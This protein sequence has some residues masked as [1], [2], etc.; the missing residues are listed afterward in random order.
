MQR[1]LPLLLLVLLVLA[2]NLPQCHTQPSKTRM[3]KISRQLS[4]ELV[5]SLKERDA[6]VAADM[7]RVER[8][9]AAGTPRAV[10]VAPGQPRRAS[11]KD[12]GVSTSL[13]GGTTAEA[14]YF[15]YIVS[16]QSLAY[17]DDNGVMHFCG[18]SLVKA[19]VVLTAAHCVYDQ[20]KKAWVYPDSVRV[21]A[22][23]LYWDDSE[24]YYH[25]YELRTVKSIIYP[26]NYNANSLVND[27]AILVLDSKVDIKYFPP[28]KLATSTQVL[29]QDQWLLAMGWGQ[30]ET[31][32]I[33]YELLWAWVPFF[34]R[35]KCFSKG[36]MNY[37]LSHIC[38]GG[39]GAANICPGDSGGALVIDGNATDT[40]VGIASFIRANVPCGSAN[41]FGYYTSIPAIRSSLDSAFKKYKL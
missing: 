16:L 17:E 37:P 33:S 5:A 15:P 18:G 35:T 21:G 28:V 24:D 1:H 12:G 29:K 2:A 23:D 8:L 40:Q 10:S 9:R 34:T 36:R 26:S 3:L 4:P 7:R 19:N 30:M 14:G 38:A 20:G 41:A 11:R 39:S 13:S 32:T 27:F 31:A 6:R 25:Y 22:L